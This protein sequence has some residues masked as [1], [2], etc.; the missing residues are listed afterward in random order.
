MEFGSEPPDGV[1]YKIILYTNRAIWLYL[2]LKSNFHPDYLRWYLLLQEFNFVVHD[3]RESGDVGEP[4]EKP[5]IDTL[6]DPKPV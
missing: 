6:T 4:I 2:M 3:K 1:H 5:T